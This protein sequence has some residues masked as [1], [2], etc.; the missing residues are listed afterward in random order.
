MQILL[1]SGKET[2]SHEE[3]YEQCSQT[4]SVLTVGIICWTGWCG[5]V[6]GIVYGSLG[7]YPSPSEVIILSLISQI[8][9]C[10]TQYVFDLE[11]CSIWISI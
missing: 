7:I 2:H 8:C 10:I 11:R 6:E 5:I 9:S 4:G 1:F 3:P